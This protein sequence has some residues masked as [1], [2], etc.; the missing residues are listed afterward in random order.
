[1]LFCYSSVQK[2]SGGGAGGK[3]S[4]H[5][6]DDPR[7]LTS[8]SVIPAE[9]LP[10]S[11]WKDC[12]VRVPGSHPLLWAPGGGSPGGWD[13]KQDSWDHPLYVFTE[14]AESFRCFKVFAACFLWS[15]S[16]NGRPIE[17]ERARK[18]A[19][20]RYLNGLVRAAGHVPRCH[21]IRGCGPG[22]GTVVGLGDLR[23]KRATGT[24]SV[25]QRDEIRNSERFH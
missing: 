10:F 4:Q 13:W 21:L 18:A 22:I 12:E 3:E 1:M 8:S 16:T 5:Q 20:E 2:T 6:N 25:G 15:F 7:P 9:R 24:A 23:Y 11:A 14:L 17:D 19:N